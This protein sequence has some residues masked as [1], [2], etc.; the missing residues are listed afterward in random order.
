MLARIRSFVAENLWNPEPL[1]P[2]PLGWLRSFFQLSAL[3]G[4]GF[5]R[6][7]LLLR[8]NSLAYLTLLSIVPFLALAVALV[9]MIGD[10]HEV[11]TRLVGLIGFSETIKTQLLDAVARLNFRAFG[12]IGGAILFA[13]TVLAVGRVEQALNALWGATERRAWSRRIPDYLAVIVIAP[14][15]VGVAIP[16]RVA[17]ESQVVVRAALH[18]PALHFL[19]LSGLR[20]AP[21]LLVIAAL[22]FLYWFLPNTR[23][24]VR[25][26]LFGG[27]VAGVLF[28]FAQV[29]Y[30]RLSVGA[31]L[32]MGT[33]FAASAWVVLFLVWVYISWA[34]VLLGAEV[35]YAHQTLSLYRREVRGKGAGPAARETIGLAVA[36]CCA[37]AF[38]DSAAPWH[39]DALSDSLDVPL[40]AVREVLSALEEAKIVTGCGGD[41]E[42]CFQMARPA[43]QIR[44]SDVLLA[45]RGNASYPLGVPEV[46]RIVNGVIADV[47]RAGGAVAEARNLRDLM[48]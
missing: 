1:E 46:S 37:R 24:R 34:I 7:Q 39:P 43:E 14:L 45:L 23:V 2:K 41:N 31:N 4:E 5:V 9:D 21:V 30:V 12:T 36:L 16:L 6:D 8:A 18:Y 20:Y 35:A 38:R 42:G 22:V 10:G 13:T 17:F 11:A 33:A 27:V 32:R 3:I 15:L 19:Y 26:A 25:S 28:N 29:A 48:G 44:V 40:R 47:E